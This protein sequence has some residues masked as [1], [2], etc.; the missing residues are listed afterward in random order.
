[1]ADMKDALRKAG[2]ERSRRSD[3]TN[4]PKQRFQFPANYPD[5]FDPDGVLR[6]EYV[7]ELADSIAKGIAGDRPKLTT[8]QLRTFYQHV[9]S[10]EKALRSGR[11]FPEVRSEISKLK[12][13][14]H[15]RQN[16]GRIGPVFR[17]FL[18]KNVDK[19]KDEKSFLAGFLEHFQAVVAYCTGR[20]S[21]K[22]RRA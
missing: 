20:I 9:K 12:P 22:E 17:E 10:Q 19:A 5:Y 16:K 4:V 14:A 11:P 15:E 1:M 8:H 3:T 6:P 2:L 13:F 21:E 18:E 7:G